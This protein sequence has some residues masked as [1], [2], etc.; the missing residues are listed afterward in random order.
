MP[1]A[2]HGEG[3]G[4]GEIARRRQFA[5]GLLA[6]VDEVGVFL[7]LIRE[8][9]HAEHAVLALQL[10]VDAVGDVVR[11][12]GRNADTEID[13][14]AVLQ[15]LRGARRHLFAGPGHGALLLS[16]RLYFARD[17]VGKP[18]PTFPDHALGRGRVL[19]NS[20]RF[21]PVPTSTMRW[22]KMPGVWMWSGSSSPAGTSCSTSATVTFAAVAIIG[23][24]LRAVLQ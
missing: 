18:V 8:R 7:A 5:H 23:L 3:I 4:R 11:H 14:I 1:A 9:P 2:H 12:Q 20:M 24:K 22:T 16:Y 21:L 15:L 19:R 6:G 10:H 13:V 17:L